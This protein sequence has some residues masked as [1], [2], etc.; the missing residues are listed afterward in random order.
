MNVAIVTVR[1]RL[2]KVGQGPSTQT[3]CILHELLSD[4]HE[5]WLISGS[6]TVNN[7]RAVISVKV[8]NTAANF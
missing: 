1:I 4:A 6:A 2:Q 3:N 5:I 8:C 7:R